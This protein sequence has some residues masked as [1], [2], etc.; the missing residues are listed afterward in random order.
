[1]TADS[2]WMVVSM[3]AF[4]LFLLAF[5]WSWLRP[6]K[7]PSSTASDIAAEQFAQGEIDADAFEHILC[8]IRSGR[9]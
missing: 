7:Q 5:A 9:P 6:A 1:M 2:I 3:I 4:C 8:D